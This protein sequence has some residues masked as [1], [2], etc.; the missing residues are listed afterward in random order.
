MYS[1][2]HVMVLQCSDQSYETAI[3]ASSFNMQWLF[4]KVILAS[5][6]LCNLQIC[7]YCYEMS[8]IDS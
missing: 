6:Y 8:E 2:V 1:H 3:N 5:L 7:K 4:L